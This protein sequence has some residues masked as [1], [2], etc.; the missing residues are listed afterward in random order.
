MA[1]AVE[2]QVKH[3]K[4]EPSD[5][6]NQHLK[7][8]ATQEIVG[9]VAREERGHKAKKPKVKHGGPDRKTYSLQGQAEAAGAPRRQLKRSGTRGSEDDTP[10]S[11]AEVK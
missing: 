7:R 11:N 4:T 2:E 10:G 6:R 1:R 3:K 8:K 9:N 5:P